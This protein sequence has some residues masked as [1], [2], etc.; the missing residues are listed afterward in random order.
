M[1]DEYA[2]ANSIQRL[3]EDS[4]LRNRLVN[5]G[6]EKVQRFGWARVADDVIDYYQEVM[7]RAPFPA[8]PHQRRTSSG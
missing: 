3:I 6:H 8:V 4:D 1:G 7:A 5:N 2:I